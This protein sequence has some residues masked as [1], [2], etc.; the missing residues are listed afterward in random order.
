MANFRGAIKIIKKNN[1]FLSLQQLSPGVQGHF[2][3][4]Q[5]MF[6]FSSLSW[7]TRYWNVPRFQPVYLKPGWK[8]SSRKYSVMSHQRSRSEI[9][10]PTTPPPHPNQGN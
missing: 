9:S 6:L 7:L 1:H 5:C 8:V 4:D 3:H 2:V 10:T